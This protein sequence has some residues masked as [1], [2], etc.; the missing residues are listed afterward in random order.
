[1]L[2]SN[3]DYTGKDNKIENKTRQKIRKRSAVSQAYQLSDRFF[4]KSS[5]T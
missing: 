5:Q 1:M 3:F 2:T 4:K